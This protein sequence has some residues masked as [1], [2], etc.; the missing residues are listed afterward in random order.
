[1]QSIKEGR[2]PSFM[3]VF[4][5]DTE[6]QPIQHKHP[7]GQ[8][9]KPTLPNNHQNNSNISNNNIPKPTTS[10]SS[11]MP[12]TSKNAKPVT[13]DAA[14]EVTMV[15]NASTYSKAGPASTFPPSIPPS[16]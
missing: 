4:D 5:P 11:T 2:V 13:S 7:T 9:L 12:F 15:D 1:M 16:H 14:S 8:R 6:N 10:I 3:M